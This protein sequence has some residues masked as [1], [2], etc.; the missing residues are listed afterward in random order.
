MAD[1]VIAGGLVIHSNE[2]SGDGRIYGVIRK[3]N[4]VTVAAVKRRVDLYLNS[5][6]GQTGRII[7][8]T[9]SRESD[10]YYEFTNL[11]IT[12]GVYNYRVVARDWPPGAS[13]QE[14]KI[15]DWVQPTPM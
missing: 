5:I 7:A 15:A 6:Y 10:G 9:F 1:G 13:V 3:D 11:K 2:F 8:S 14:A 12:D 4:G